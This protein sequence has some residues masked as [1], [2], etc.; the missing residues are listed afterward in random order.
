[1]KKVD[2]YN[3]GKTNLF[4]IIVTINNTPVTK[5]KYQR[6]YEKHSEKYRQRSKRYY[7]N[8]REQTLKW[9]KIDTED[10]LMRKKIR[11]RILQI[12]I[13]EYVWV[14]QIKTTKIGKRIK[15]KIDSIMCWKKQKKTELRKHWFENNFNK[16]FIY[17]AH[18]KLNK[19]FDLGN[20]IPYWIFWAS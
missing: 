3:Y 7:E 8:N 12:S 1:M 13:L 4:I 2:N 16:L 14:R 9:L 6:Y 20:V 18:K 11:K 19:V 5:T 15:K 10:Y 17:C